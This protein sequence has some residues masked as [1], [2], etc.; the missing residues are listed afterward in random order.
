MIAKRWKRKGLAG[1]IFVAVLLLSGCD[2]T[3]TTVS[4]WD[5]SGGVVTIVDDSLAL[6]NY[7]RGEDTCEEN[8]WSGLEDCE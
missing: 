8:E 3:T 7:A 2:N 1:V 6:V 5:R 4:G